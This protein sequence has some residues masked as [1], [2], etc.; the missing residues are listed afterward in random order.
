[1]L[2]NLKKF[3]NNFQKKFY[4]I[5]TKINTKNKL[6]PDLDSTTHEL[7]LLKIKNVFKT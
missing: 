5:N 1:M 2:Q 7:K 6:V 3:Y 4:K